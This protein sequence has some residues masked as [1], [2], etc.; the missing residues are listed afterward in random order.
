MVRGRCGDRGDSSKGTGDLCR[1]DLDQIGE[2]FLEKLRFVQDA[3]RNHESPKHPTAF[4]SQIL[5]FQG[6]H[7]NQGCWLQPADSWLSGPLPL[8][9]RLVYRSCLEE[10]IGK[11]RRE[12]IAG[13]VGVE[14]QMERGA[15][16][17][18]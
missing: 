13:R 7:V 16:S 18:S 2:S 11:W 6:Q 1:D 12:E 14:K 10:F 5:A 17:G 8:G 15:G 9:A 4:L 3:G